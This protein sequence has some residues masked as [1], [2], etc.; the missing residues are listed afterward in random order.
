MRRSSFVTLGLYTALAAATLAAPAA[1]QRGMGEAQGLTRQGATLPMTMLSGVVR[2]LK[3]DTCEQT[4]G[5]AVTGVHA[6]VETPDHGTV[7]LHL[8]PAV[9]LEDLT[10]HLQPGEDLSAEAFRTDIMPADAFVARTVTVDGTTFELRGPTLR[11]HWAIGPGGGPKG[12]AGMGRGGGVGQG[13][14]QG[15][16]MGRSGRPCW[17]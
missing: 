14:G 13:M 5:R 7:N 16:G 8:G 9:A 15:Q 17:W 12:G 11:P 1:A 10:A 2:D 4:T 6:I 3:I